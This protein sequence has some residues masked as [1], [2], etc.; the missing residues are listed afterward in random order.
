MRDY[1]DNNKTKV[2]TL[3]AEEFIRRYLLH[4][5]PSKFTRIRHIGFLANRYK[6]DKLKQCRTALNFEKKPMIEETTDELY[7]VFITLT[8]ISAFIVV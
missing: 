7:Y 3:D 4:V 6:A 5:L 8:F 1:A 2:M